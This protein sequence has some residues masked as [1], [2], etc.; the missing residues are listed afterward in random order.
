M[1]AD[2]PAD[3]SEN[4]RRAGRKMLLLVAGAVACAAVLHL[5][6]L[7]RS[8]R[9]LQAMKE[10]LR[11]AGFLSAV[12]F[13]GLTAA[14]VA[15]GFPRLFASAL[16]GMLFGFALGLP[17]SVSGA[18]LGSYGTFL[19]ARWAGREWVARRFPEK[20]A[21]RSLLETPSVA[22]VFWVR[23]LPV[24]GFIINIGLGLTAVR[25]RTFLLGSALGFL[26]LA[27]VVTLVGSGLAKASPVHSAVQI[28]T[29][30]AA[31]LVLALG[32]W[33]SIQKMEARA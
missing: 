31:A 29:A 5:T 18:L 7:G 25:H 30:G 9:D 20:G 23:Q 22:G 24:A 10:R 12:A 17:L 4:L 32:L 2:L 33:R 27:A 3:A 26:P 1:S 15:A 8:L 16:G 19:F 6:P 11:A 28:G 13:T 14:L 21:L